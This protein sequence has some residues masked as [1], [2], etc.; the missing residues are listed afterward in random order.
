[1]IKGTVRGWSGHPVIPP[2]IP[3]IPVAVHVARGVT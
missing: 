2:R 3:R 1:M